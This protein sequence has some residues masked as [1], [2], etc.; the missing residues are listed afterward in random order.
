MIIDLL[1]IFLASVAVY[2]TWGGG[3]VRQFLASGGFFGGLLLGR[4][5]ESYTI[6]PF[7]TSTSRVVVTLITILGIAICCLIIGEFIGIKLKYHL[8]ARRLNKLDNGMGALLTVCSV[9]VSAWL[10]ASVANSLPSS[11]LSIAMNQSRIISGLNRLLPSAPNVIADLGKLIDPNGFPDVFIGTEPIPKGNVNLPALGSLLNAV[12]ADKTSVV[13]IQGQGCGGIVSGSGFVVAPGLV[14]TDAHVVA[15][16]KH[17]VAQDVN[18]PHPAHVI[19][20]DPN[21]DLAIL[22]VSGLAG[23]PL[24]LDA[25]NAAS[26]TPAVVL[27]Y[28]GGGEFNAGPAAVLDEFAASGHNI[29]GSGLTL[30][31]VYEIQATVIP[32][33]SGGPLVTKNGDVIGVVFAASTS[34]NHVGYA[35]TMAKV[36]TEIQRARNNEAA[37]IG[38]GACAQ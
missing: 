36:I 7:H 17:S 1:I 19:L 8:L 23:T 3:F 31:S 38:T 37:V 16:I 5:L 15:G 26:G 18:G 30:R 27:G 22:R 14:A 13:R 28:P 32:G 25:N 33:N 4:W 10:L 2:R 35:L 20:F 9:L 24:N 21:L 34:Y 11:Q 29:Y 6:R 12:N